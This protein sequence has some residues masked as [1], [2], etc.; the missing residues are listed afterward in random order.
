[1]SSAKTVAQKPAGNVNP[2]SS[3]GHAWLLVSAP[4]VELLWSDANE[5]PTHNAPSVAMAGNRVLPNPDNRMEH[6]LKD[7][8]RENKGVQ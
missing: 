8:R 2:L 5:L 4:G 7:R 6:S 1:M 3:L